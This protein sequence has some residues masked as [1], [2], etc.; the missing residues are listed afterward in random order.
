MVIEGIQI[1]NKDPTLKGLKNF[2]DYWTEWIG[3]LKDTRVENLVQG[4]ENFSHEL[5]EQ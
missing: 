4:K 2:L 3:L 5:K 1:P